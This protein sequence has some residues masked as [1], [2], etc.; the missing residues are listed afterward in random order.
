M[1][2]HYYL[3]ELLGLWKSLLICKTLFLCTCNK[4]IHD[5]GTV[6]ESVC[7]V[8]IYHITPFG[9][10]RHILGFGQKLRLGKLMA[11][12]KFSP[13]LSGVLISGFSHELMFLYTKQQALGKKGAI[14]M[15]AITGTVEVLI[16]VLQ[17]GFTILA[18]DK[19]THTHTE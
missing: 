16:H 8:Q 10:L 9:S 5:L 15:F 17:K 7:S 2:L 19:H 14:L 4:W 11:S 12:R 1:F 6:Y 13:I 18:T 3:M